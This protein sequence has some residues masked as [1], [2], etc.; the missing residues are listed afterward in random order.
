MCAPTDKEVSVTPKLVITIEIGVMGMGE[1]RDQECLLILSN[2][3]ECP[4]FHLEGWPFLDS[5]TFTR[6]TAFSSPTCFLNEFLM[7]A[8][9]IVNICVGYTDKT[10][11]GRR[12][13]QAQQNSS[14]SQEWGTVWVWETWQKHL[15]VNL[16]CFYPQTILVRF[17]SVIVNLSEPWNI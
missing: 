10:T 1:S 14:N 6:F 16:F 7:H 2:G 17:S 13:Q 12:E 8:D 15:W 5:V 9:T 3:L 4:V 11:Y